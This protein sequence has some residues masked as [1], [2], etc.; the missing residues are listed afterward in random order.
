MP[1]INM[2]ATRRAERKKLERHVRM[3]ALIVLCQVVLGCA[4]LSFMT[5]RIYATDRNI[6][7]LDAQLA[8]I[9]PTVKQIAEYE[10]QTKQLQPRL[11]LLAD[12]REK[13]LLWYSVMQN[14]SRSM[15]ANTWLTDITTVKTARPSVSTAKPADGA[16]AAPPPPPQVSVKL[17]GMS[18]SQMMVGE[19]ML[20][21][22]RWPEFKQVDLSYTQQGS[23]NDL[24]TVEFEINAQL[25]DRGT[26]G[27]ESPNGSN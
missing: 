24:T 22:N 13:T 5:A 12:S 20:R 23:S 26:K 1:S 9:Q 11:L 8:R 7:K 14:L 27:G 16:P 10:G 6:D 17:R 25:L 19:T 4:I 21:L 18:T 3:A 2:I 15:P